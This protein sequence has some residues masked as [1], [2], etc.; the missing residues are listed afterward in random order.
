LLDSLE[1]YS[2]SFREIG[3]TG[4]Q[5]LGLI[6]QGLAAGARNGDQV[7]DALKEVGIRAQDASTTS[8]QG[9]KAIGLNAAEMTRI[10]A[11]GGPEAGAALDTVLDRLRKM[12]DPVARN[13]AAVAL[14]GTKAEDLGDALFALDPSSAVETLGKVDGAAQAVNNT[15]S[16]TVSSKIEGWKRTIQKNVVDY[17]S[18]T[19]LPFFKDLAG[20]I[21]VGQ[22]IEGIK[23]T[24][25]KVAVF[26]KQ[27]MA[28][29]QEWA[30]SHQEEIQRFVEAIKTA[31][32]K[33]KVYIDEFIALA[34]AIWDAFGS[35]AIAT[36]VNH[37]TAAV[38][39]IGGI[40]QI[41]G[42][43]FTLIKGLVTGDWSAMWEGIK[44]IASGAG[45]ILGGLIDMVIGDIVASMG[46][47]WEKIKADAKATW[48]RIVQF[49]KDAV[50]TVLNIVGFI[51]SLPGRFV[52]WWQGILDG[53]T[54]KTNEILAFVRSI[55]GRIID[56]FMSIPGQ[57]WGIG[58]NIIGSL[59]DGMKSKINGAIETVKEMA[60]SLP[61]WVKKTL[62]IASP[63][64]VFAAIGRFVGQGL[65]LGL[66]AS[67]NPVGLAGMRLATA[68]IPNIGQIPT[69]S[70]GAIASQPGGPGGV[71]INVYGSDGQSV[72]SLAEAVANKQRILGRI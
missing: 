72:E 61:D 52:A 6:N 43:L 48:D 13:A 44:S 35:E 64:K 46:G 34:K 47:D 20:K 49:V 37:L 14:F 3:V 29:I 24:V 16:D 27:V 51:S 36:L 30:N 12:E 56:A 25:G 2:T 55:P 45:A 8:A 50:F 54:T 21:D 18:N 60:R 32:A 67:I 58:S 63:S 33:A 15:L 53:I 69:G 17:M 41:I 28:D 22:I 10:F 9:F 39:I 66:D 71:T 1:E 42:G 62:G 57:L 40:F 4:K 59:I 38:N 65:V 31:F 11:K 70:D 5:G 23:D 7:A 19:V 26:L 68:A